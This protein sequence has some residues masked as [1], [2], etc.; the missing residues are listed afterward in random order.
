[1]LTPGLLLLGVTPSV[2]VG[3]DLLIASVMRLFGGG[4]Y[5]LRGQVHWPSV[6]WL[7]CGSIPGALVGVWLLNRLSATQVDSFLRNSVGG[8]LMLAGA[9]MLLRVLW[10]PGSSRGP[11]PRPWVTVSL[12]AMVG[13]LVSVTT[14]GSGSLL[15]CVFVVLFPLSPP[16]LVGTDLVH[17]LLLS[18]TA[19]LAQLASGRVDVQLAGWVLLGGIPGVLLGTK[20]AARVPERVMRGGLACVLVGLGL[21]LI[22]VSEKVHTPPPMVAGQTQQ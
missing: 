16:V 14:I 10:R 18:G 15:L 3:T 5:A 7:A 22:T 13:V 1:M 19:T 20:L 11:M 8:V 4:I 12:G 6:R 9:S 2:A 17:A 21:N